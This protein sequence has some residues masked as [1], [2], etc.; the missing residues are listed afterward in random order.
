[1]KVSMVSDKKMLPNP[2]IRISWICN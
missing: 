2:S 1:M